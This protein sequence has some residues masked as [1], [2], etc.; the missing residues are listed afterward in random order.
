MAR[1]FDELVDVALRSS[2]SCGY[3]ARASRALG[4][5]IAE[6]LSRAGATYPEVEGN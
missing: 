2:G 3:C 6:C 5:F 4:C 1:Q